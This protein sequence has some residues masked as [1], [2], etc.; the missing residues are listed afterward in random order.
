MGTLLP[1]K[2]KEAYIVLRM[3]NGVGIVIGFGA[4]LFSYSYI[5]LL[6]A[7]G[8]IVFTFIVFFCVG[9]Y[10]M[11]KKKAFFTGEIAMLTMLVVNYI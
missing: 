2:Q 8:L 4:A 9:N 7:L 3:S 6:I 5:Q 11:D 10:V 1:N